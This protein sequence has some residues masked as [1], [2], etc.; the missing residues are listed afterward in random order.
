MDRF[1]RVRIAA[2][3]VLALPG[4]ELGAQL[5]DL[6]R[7]VEIDLALSALPAPLRPGA[8]VLV[9]EPGVGLAVAREGHNG[10]TAFVSRVEPAVFRS[11]RPY[12]RHV[13]DVLL[14][15]AFDAAGVDGPMRPFLDAAELLA[16]G[17]DPAETHRIMRANFD[18]GA[19]EPAP[20]P[21]VAYML[22][23]VARAYPTPLDDDR[24]LT[25]NIPHRMFYAPHLAAADIGGPRTASTQAYVIQSG[26]HAYLGDQSGPEERDEINREHAGL[27][28]RL[29]GLHL[30]WCL[31]GA[32]RGARAAALQMPWSI[33][34]ADWDAFVTLFTEDALMYFPFR[35]DRAEGIEE[36]TGAMRPI[37]DRNRARGPGPHFGFRPRDVRVSMLGEDSAVVTWVMD[38]GERLSRRTVV[39]RQVDG[40]WKI[41]LVHADNAA[42]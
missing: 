7:E 42:T 29:C 25:F 33:D 2:L 6:P 28:D 19:Y 30:E 32:R 39:V 13:P 16:T 21:G 3:I 10:F 11:D 27:I 22:A 36:I 38:V 23:P 4:S 15:V 12:L 40:A 24:V 17:T 26:P 34:H 9:M 37:F 8:T 5:V 18:S 14:P 35:A 41:A 31:P 1:D 20:R